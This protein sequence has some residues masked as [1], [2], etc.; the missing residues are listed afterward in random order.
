[1][2]RPGDEVLQLLQKRG[3]VVL[4]APFVKYGAL[5]RLLDSC[6]PN[7]VV[8]VIVRWHIEDLWAGV[9]DLSIW[10]LRKAR[11][12]LVLLMRSGLHA[13]YYRCESSCL[14]GSANITDAGLGWS[15]FPNLELLVESPFSSN[16]QRFEELTIGSSVAITEEV[17]C[18]LNE[19]MTQLRDERSRAVLARSG[20][21]WQLSCWRPEEGW[22][23][24]TKDPNDL[25]RLYNGKLEDLASAVQ[26]NAVCDLR[27]LNVPLDLNLVGFQAFVRSRL[28]TCPVFVL[29]ESK[30]ASPKRFSE[31]RR[32]VRAELG[33]SQEVATHKT[34][35]LVRWLLFFAPKTYRLETASYVETITRAT[36]G[37]GRSRRNE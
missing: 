2:T 19:I 17:V 5:K 27:M 35:I 12:G 34:Q 37:G 29:V 36:P 21:G 23:P 4:I 9:S 6:D 14:V 10:D 11:P 32:I 30:L 1:M 8:T 25:W 20:F 26:S 3:A 15:D 31:L 13:K 7:A 33:I 18:E 22:I 16:L 24:A 28:L